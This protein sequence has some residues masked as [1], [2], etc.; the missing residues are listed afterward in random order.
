MGSNADDK[1]P[2]NLNTNMNKS[3]ISD[4]SFVQAPKLKSKQEILNEVLFW[5][6]DVW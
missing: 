1:D 5:E 4:S 2:D 3:A 6:S